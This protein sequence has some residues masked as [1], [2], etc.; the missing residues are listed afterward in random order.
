MQQAG[1]LKSFYKTVEKVQL[2][3]GAP[4]AAAAAAA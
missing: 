1:F 3:D 2:R 4:A